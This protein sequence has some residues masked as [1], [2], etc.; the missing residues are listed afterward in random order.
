MSPISR[1]QS[2][3]RSTYDD[4]RAPVSWWRPQVWL[5]IPAYLALIIALGAACRALAHFI[6]NP[7]VTMY[8]WLAL[9]LNSAVSFSALCG[10]GALQRW[11]HRARVLLVLLLPLAAV[12]FNA[13]VLA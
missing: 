10:A 4:K 8:L 6:T 9:I 2:T 11:S 12:L 1:F 3:L 13:S 5:Y 7:D